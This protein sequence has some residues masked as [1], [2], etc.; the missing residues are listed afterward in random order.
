MCGTTQ[1]KGDILKRL[2]SLF[3]SLSVI[4]E[5]AINNLRIKDIIN[6]MINHFTVVEVQK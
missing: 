5:F 3:P 4:D 2:T 1:S 6:V